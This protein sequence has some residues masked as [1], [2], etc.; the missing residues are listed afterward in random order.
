MNKVRK[1]NV[2]IIVSIVS[3][4]ARGLSWAARKRFVVNPPL[5]AITVTEK[6][7]IMGAAEDIEA[8]LN[9]PKIGP[10]RKPTNI[11]IKVSGILVFLD[12]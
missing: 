5:N 7:I 2:E 4:K 3:F 11:N 9:I 10:I 8:S 12:R 6:V 1:N